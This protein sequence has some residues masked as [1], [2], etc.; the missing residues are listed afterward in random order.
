MITVVG[1]GP[2]HLDRIPGPV[3]A[4]LQN[5]RTAVVVRTLEHPAAQEL[6]E[7][8]EVVSCD[9]LYR[10]GD[11]FGDVYDAIVDRLRSY[12]GDVIYA[13]PGSATV[14]EFVVRHLLDSGADVEVVAGKSFVDAI[15]DEVG[16]DPLQRG[17]TI[18]NAHDLPDPLI[19][20]TPT[21][22]GQLDLPVVVAD[23]SGRLTRMMPEDTRVKILIGLGTDEQRVVETHVAAIDPGLASVATSMFIDATPGGLVGAIRTMAELR[24]ECP[25]DRDQTRESLV[26]YLFEEVAEFADAVSGLEGDDDWVGIGHVAD[27]LGD[28]LLQVLFHSVIASD[29]GQF[30]LDDVAEGLR[31]KLVRRHP[32]VF[33]DVRVEGADDVRANWRKIKD[34]ERGGSGGSIVDGLPPDVSALAAAYRIQKR[35]AG[36]GFDW[37]E[38]GGVRAKVDEEL[39]ELD[40]AETDADRV[41]ELGDVLFSVVNLSRHLGIDP[42]LALRRA[43]S[44]FSTRVRAMEEEGPLDGLD[45]AEL[46]RRWEASKIHG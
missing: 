34:D 19:L 20:T 2:G 41:D 42:D 14:G 39:G 3:R 1:L 21:I 7:L 12:H 40:R 22:I 4:V 18:L 29:H 23:L 33:G 44:R 11:S 46:D 31:Q 37:S 13:V 32:H 5:P 6:A 15:L 35:M 28:V 16:Y 24:R 30:D 38:I 8:R 10:D 26:P 17:L 45:S 25:W 43:V 27:E 9:D 36:V